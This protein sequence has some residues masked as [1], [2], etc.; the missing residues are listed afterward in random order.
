MVKDSE[1]TKILNLKIYDKMVDLCVRDGRNQVGSRI[2]EIVGSKNNLSKF[3]ERLRH[4]QG[5]GMTRL[6]ISILPAAFE[7][8]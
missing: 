1:K 4:A 7:K 3:N 6:E 2:K 5:A 8:Y